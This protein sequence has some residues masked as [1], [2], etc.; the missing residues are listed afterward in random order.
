[1]I[2]VGTNLDNWSL[3]IGRRRYT[4]VKDAPTSQRKIV[5][6]LWSVIPAGGYDY[7]GWFSVMTYR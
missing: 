3:T 5:E 2:A 6:E 4:A 1:G 7:S